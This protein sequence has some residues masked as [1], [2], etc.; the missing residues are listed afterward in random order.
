M[1]WTCSLES[2]M[3][4]REA[5]QPSQEMFA[6]LWTDPM[7]QWLVTALAQG[8]MEGCQVV[9]HGVLEASACSVPSSLWKER[10]AAS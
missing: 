10:A 2:K 6:W 5:K 8:G 1:R 3:L 9:G 7:W 4:T